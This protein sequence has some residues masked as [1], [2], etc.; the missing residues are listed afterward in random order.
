MVEGG[1]VTP[2]HRDPVTAGA[3]A[4]GLPRDLWPGPAIG[5]TGHQGRVAPAMP[6]WAMPGNDFPVANPAQ[7]VRLGQVRR[8]VVAGP[9]LA[10]AAAGRRITRTRCQPL[11]SMAI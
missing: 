4:C 3:S 5:R 9:C 7:F 6:V 11:T 8:A 1:Q 2:H 10:A